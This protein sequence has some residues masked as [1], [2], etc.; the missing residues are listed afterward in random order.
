M[1]PFVHVQR[2]TAMSDFR[3]SSQ[4]YK[5]FDVPIVSVFVNIGMRSSNGARDATKNSRHSVQVVYTTRVMGLGVFR[6]EW[7]QKR[8]TS[9]WSKTYHSKIEIDATIFVFYTKTWHELSILTVRYA[10]PTVLS[11]PAEQPIKRA[12]HGLI[13]IFDAVP[14]AT[15]PAR[16]AFW[17]WTYRQERNNFWTFGLHYL[18]FITILPLSCTRRCIE[19]VERFQVKKV[20]IS[21]HAQ[22]PFGSFSLEK[23]WQRECGHT[24]SSQWEVCVNDGAVLCNVIRSH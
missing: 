22:S 6:Q 12:P 9:M 8:R 21:H 2:S 3:K 7:L 17:T 14:T 16:V 19:M 13:D 4:R 11:A 18:M 20:I 15:P 10:Y 23:W 5:K 1:K 24:S